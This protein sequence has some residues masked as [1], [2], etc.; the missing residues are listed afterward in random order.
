MGAGLDCGLG[1]MRAPS[2]THNAAAVAVCL[3]RRCMNV[4]PLR[5]LAYP[6]GS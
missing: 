5:S 2:M 1:G 4:M 3:L 6:E